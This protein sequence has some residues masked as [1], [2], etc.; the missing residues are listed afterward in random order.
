MRQSLRLV[1]GLYLKLSLLTIAVGFLLR[2]VL[3]F[4]EQTTDLGFS[5]GEW[6]QVFLLGAVN[7]LCAATIGFVFLWLFSMSSVL[8]PFSA[9]SR[10]SFITISRSSSAISSFVSKRISSL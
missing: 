3:L 10:I 8:G 7:D 4:N 1:S 2:I 6:L 5:F 9:I